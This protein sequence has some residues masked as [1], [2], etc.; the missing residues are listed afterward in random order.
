MKLTM[1]ICTYNNDNFDVIFEDK[2]TGQHLTLS[3]NQKLDEDEFQ[4]ANQIAPACV[5]T[6]YQRITP[7]D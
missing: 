7:K 2:E 4:F 1:S 3:G 5:Y 6:D